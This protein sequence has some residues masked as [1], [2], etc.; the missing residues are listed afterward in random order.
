MNTLKDSTSYQREAQQLKKMF[1][2]FHNDPIAWENIEKA[3]QIL[4]D[5]PENLHPR[6]QTSPS[7]K[8]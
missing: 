6:K 3:K 7:Q 4:E 2:E 5:I 1:E 8:S